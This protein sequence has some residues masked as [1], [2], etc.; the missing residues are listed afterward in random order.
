M[1]MRP[2]NHDR[3]ATAL[4]FC[5]K[6]C[7]P[8]H[9]P[10]PAINAVSSR[11]GARIATIPS[12]TSRQHRSTQRGEEEEREEGEG[13]RAKRSADE[14]D[15]GTNAGR[16]DTRSSSKKTF[17]ETQQKTSHKKPS[18]LQAQAFRRQALTSKL[19]QQSKLHCGL[20]YEERC[21]LSLRYKVLPSGIS[22][23]VQPGGRG[24]WP[25]SGACC[26]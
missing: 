3:R 17:T 6:R 1:K 11:R 5:S 19:S 26:C 24:R 22:N 4:C 7:A 8:S 21:S 12:A 25:P 16:Q 20:S 2:L 14:S 23:S 9:D 13:K 10:A 15:S 18:A